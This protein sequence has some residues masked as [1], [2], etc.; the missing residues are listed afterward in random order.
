MFQV[1]TSEQNTKQGLGNNKVYNLILY[2]LLIWS[3]TT[4]VIVQTSPFIRI[5]S[6]PRN[7]LT[8]KFIDGGSP[9]HYFKWKKSIHISSKNLKQF[10]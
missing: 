1:T 10:P 7:V 5:W 6:V 3:E 9:F 4:P 8:S 2:M